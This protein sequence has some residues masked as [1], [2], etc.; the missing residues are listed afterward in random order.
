VQADDIS[1]S[2][3]DAKSLGATVMKCVTD[4]TGYGWFRVIL[5]PTGAALELSEPKKT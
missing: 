1:P 2:T 5:D 3:Q 4:V